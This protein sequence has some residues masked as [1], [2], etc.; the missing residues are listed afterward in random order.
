MHLRDSSAKWCREAGSLTVVGVTG[1]EQE[2]GPPFALFDPF[3]GKACACD[4]AAFIAKA[5]TSGSRASRRD[6]LRAVPPACLAA[7]LDRR[8]C[9]QCA[10]ARAVPIEGD[11]PDHGSTFISWAFRVRACVQWLPPVAIHQATTLPTGV[12]AIRSDS[13]CAPVRAA[14]RAGSGAG[15][16]PAPSPPETFVLPGLR[17][18]RYA[19]GRS[20]RCPRCRAPSSMLL[21]HEA[22]PRCRGHDV[23][24][25]LRSAAFVA[26]SR[27]RSPSAD[28]SSGTPETARV[29]G[30]AA[31]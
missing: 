18:E 20:F 16:E 23:R 8:R 6:R 10:A 12:P 30:S 3:L 27:L 31:V 19:S 22:G 11:T 15:R 28:R 25:A 26:P 2:P 14:V 17:G 9:Q 5:G 29:R 21:V 1:L 7:A 4:I 24:Q 13:R